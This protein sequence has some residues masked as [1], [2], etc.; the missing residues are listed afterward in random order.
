VLGVE[1]DAPALR[2]EV[3]DR[4][5]D[6]RDVLR[7]GGAQR[8][9]DV[10]AP[11]LPD[12]RDDLGAR[13]EQ[14]GELRVVLG[15]A[16]RA[17]VIPKATSVAWSSASSPSAA[18]AKNSVSFGFAPGPAALDVGDAELVHR[19]GDAQLVLDGQADALAL[20]AVTERRVVQVHAG[21]RSGQRRVTTAV[22]RHVD[23]SPGDPG[24]T[25]GPEVPGA[26]EAGIRRAAPA[27]RHAPAT[28][29]SE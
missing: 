24:H 6:H 29:A 3:T 25:F 11:R 17:R 4:V 1:H 28:G 23:P 21:A 8:L 18:R 15:G 27:A 14:R 2:P 12:E 20:G 9:V 10:V 13:V 16:P 7:A 19:P 26:G 22:R 5:G